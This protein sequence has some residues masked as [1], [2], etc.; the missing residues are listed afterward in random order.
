M[1][2]AELIISREKVDAVIFNVDGVVTRVTTVHIEA[3]KRLF[4][5][6][7]HERS[8]GQGEDY[9]P[10]DVE[11]DYHRYID[12][13][14]RNQAVKHFLTK[15]YIELP[16]G[17][18]GDPPDR[19][20]VCGLGNRKN[21]IFNQIMEERGVEVYGCAI[22]LIHRLRKA[23][24][25][26]A[27]VSASKH[28]KLIM[29]RAEIAGLFDARVD[30][31]DAERL[32]LD[33][34]P[35]PDT[36][37]EAAKRIET[38]PARAAVFEDSLIGVTAGQ[39]GRFA[40]VVGL[41]RGGQAEKLRNQGAHAVLSDLCGVDVEATEAAQ[42]R[43]F[44]TPLAK[45][46]L[47]SNRLEDKRPALF[48]DF[49]GTLATFEDRPEN[50]RLSEDMRSILREAARR[51]PV[52]VVSGRDIDEV[53]RLVDLPEIIYAGSHGLEIRGPDLCLEVP[54]GLDALDQL[55][56]AAV[57]L[58]RALDTVSG[59]RLERKRFTVVIY[60]HER[61]AQVLDQIESAIARV[62]QRFPRLHRRGGKQVIE[63]LPDIDW[64]KGRAVSWLLSELGLEGAD[65]LPIYIGDDETDED[66]FR[67]V[68]GRGLGILV[69]ERAQASVAEYRV[70]D[71]A[72]V[73]ALLRHLVETA[74]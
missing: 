53:R 59:V 29:E 72:S 32:D 45:M 69:S 28:C 39:R 68:R 50:S 47:V 5:A 61:T 48:L 51:M 6:Y 24:I 44:P 20:T 7:L 2:E 74:D 16:V 11:H 60:L 55:G 33:G 13:R 56:K 26:T 64:D 41:D 3:W 40:L 18:P 30:A 63:L 46:S 67:I 4:D 12:G 22:A 14:P 19:E 31:V 25:R 57:E 21:Q 73:A 23:G 15:R 37:W 10:F 9:R 65:V 58:T 70:D 54:E 62:L 35:D 34:K 49:G 71:T 52:V 1:R 43:L 27:A 38:P 66:A 42:G 8:T 36:L 17:D